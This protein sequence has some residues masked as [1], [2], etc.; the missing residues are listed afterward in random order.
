MTPSPSDPA[1]RAARDD[2]LVA[3]FTALA[4]AVQVLESAVP[5]P[6]PGV[7]PGLANLVVLIVLL[8]HGLRLAA[9]VAA[10]RVLVGSLALGTFL[11]P[12][13]ALSVAGASTSFGALALVHALGRGAVGPIGYSAASAL[14]HMAGQLALAAVLLV[15]PAA[16]APLVPALLGFATATGVAGGIIARTVLSRTPPP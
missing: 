2:A 6:L 10:L 15:P 14:A 7:K 9:W 16:L 5:M 11:T 1:A 12:G 3:G 13:F 4:V 8:R